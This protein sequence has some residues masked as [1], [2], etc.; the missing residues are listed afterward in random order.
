MRLRV[1][2]Y[3]TQA[4]SM[5]QFSP[6]T[7]TSRLSS[8]SLIPVKRS[9][10]EGRRELSPNSPRALPPVPIPEPR[11]RGAA[12]E[13]NKGHGSVPSSEGDEKSPLLHL[14]SP[15]LPEDNHRG[16]LEQLFANTGRVLGIRVTQEAVVR[17]SKACI[18]AAKVESHRF[19]HG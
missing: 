8:G 16:P 2:H 13:W 18:L 5:F 14:P 1:A 15:P 10:E 17:S 4:R 6:V 12:V 7:S 19:G 3:V 9:T 11:Q